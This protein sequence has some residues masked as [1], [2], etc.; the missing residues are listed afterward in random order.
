MVVKF[1]VGPIS[2]DIQPP[3]KLIFPA[4]RSCQLTGHVSYDKLIVTDAICF[5][6]S[7]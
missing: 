6:N 7:T 2:D 1:S 5:P 3:R 4:M